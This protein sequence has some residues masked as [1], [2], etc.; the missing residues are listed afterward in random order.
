MGFVVQHTML[1]F[2]FNNNNKNDDDDGKPSTAKKKS[3][4]ERAQFDIRKP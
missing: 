2:R 4:N 1:V 3:K